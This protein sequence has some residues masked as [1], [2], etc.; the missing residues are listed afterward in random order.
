MG[1]PASRQL[2]GELLGGWYPNPWLIYFREHPG[3]YSSMAPVPQSYLSPT[4]IL[5]HSHNNNHHNYTD[6]YTKSQFPTNFPT[7]SLQ[8]ISMI[9]SLQNLDCCIIHGIF[10]L[11]PYV[12][13]C[14]YPVV[15]KELRSYR[16]PYSLYIPYELGS[17][18][19]LL[20][21]SQPNDSFPT[22]E[23]PNIIIIIMIIIQ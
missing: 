22:S 15:R 5:P 6:R 1:A 21:V 18:S 8:K 14:C 17:S 4:I 19:E 11:Y 13:R 10:L 3:N 23:C 12:Y 2:V 9:M 7:L 16:Y 20:W